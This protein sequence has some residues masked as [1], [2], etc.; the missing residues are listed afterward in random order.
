MRRHRRLVV[1]GLVGLVMAAMLSAVSM[2]AADISP[3]NI[4]KMMLN[5]LPF[6]DLNP[7]WLPADEAIVF[8]I[9]L[10]R[11]VAGALVG[12]SLA[13]AGVLFQGLLRN[14]MA[15]PYIIGTAAG[16]GLG[17]T[18]AMMLPFSAALYGFGLVPIAAFFGAL[19]TVL[20]VYNLARVGGKTPIVSMLLAGFAVSAMLAAAISLLMALSGRFQLDLRAVLSFLMGSVSVTDWNQIAII[21]PLV[22]GGIIAARFFALHLN[23]FSLGEESAAYLGI[24]VEREKLII[25]ALGSL[26]TA[27][28]ISLGGLIGFVG[29]VMPHAVRILL[30]PDHRLLLPASALAGAVFLV[31]ADTLARTVLAPTEIPVG[32]IT[33]LIGAPFFLYLLRRTRREYAF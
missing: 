6:F 20:L 33:A 13:T 22:I 14:P 12:A 11:V 8:Q 9:R 1:F 31:V 16:A 26:L 18:L 7:T 29:L 25:L 24:N 21:V 28:A 3:L 32:I 4:V 19:V 30:G 10:P 27:A 17:A 2:G 23:A 15:D 5:K